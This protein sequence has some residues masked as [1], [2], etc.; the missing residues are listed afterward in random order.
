MKARR[1]DPCPCGSGKKYKKC[2][3]ASDRQR[4][5]E[6]RL[7]PPR[8]EWEN[9]E[10]REDGLS[11]SSE[12]PDEPLRPELT[13]AMSG[14]ADSC[15]GDDSPDE[16]QVRPDPLNEARD[17]L[18][19][20]FE[21]RDYQDQIALFLKTFDTPELLGDGMAFEM[22]AAIRR[23]V[24]EHDD[25]DAFEILVR[26]FRERLPETF[27]G[28]AACCISWLIEERVARG[29]LD[30]LAPLA[31]EIAAHAGDDIDTFDLVFDSLAYHCNLSTLVEVMRIGWSGVRSSGDIL[32]WGVDE[33]VDRAF[34]LEMLRYCERAVRPKPDDPALIERLASYVTDVK[35]DSVTEFVLRV[36][37]RAQRITSAD[38]W[39]IESCEPLCLEFLG[40]LVRECGVSPGKADLGC[41]NLCVYLL[42]RLNGRM[43]HAPQLYDPGRRPPKRKGKSHRTQRRAVHVLCPDTK[44]FDPYL[45]RQ[46]GFF[47]ARYHKV[48]ATMEIIPAWFRFLELR[49]LI[50][51]R[52]H[53]DTLRNLSGL[54]AD[55]LKL[56]KKYPD[57][58]SLFP[59]AVETWQVP[60]FEPQQA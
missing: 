12:W 49:Q 21:T 34:R 56:W 58:P 3:L 27:D 14:P 53:H 2:C 60:Q 39:R 16:S 31:T 13:A 22:L 4:C 45:A 35:H 59:A 25:W 29:R 26:A 9:E 30:D 6:D 7:Q 44:T 5:P 48:A 1:N 24:K 46:L 28:T 18:W 10:P 38:Q 11:G 36:T 19:N 8:S 52:E 50:D 23:G 51:A 17:A 32:P 42:Q 15:C 20:E 54:H 37:G 47:S 57:D 41:E 33:F 43:K 55:L 40:H